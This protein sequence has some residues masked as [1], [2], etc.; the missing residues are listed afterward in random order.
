MSTFN[1]QKAFTL[2]EL[3]VVIG[4]AGIFVTVSA[5]VYTTLRQR[6]NLEVVAREVQ[7]VFNLARDRALASDGEQNFGVYVNIAT[8]E[9][10]L[11]PGASYDAGNPNNE[12]FVIPANIIVF[13]PQFEGGGNEAVFNRLTGTTSQF[14]QLTLQ[15]MAD[16]SKTS[17]ICIF[18]TGTVETRKTTQCGQAPLGHANGTIDADLANFPGHWGD[19]AQSFTTGTSALYAREAQLYLRRTTL[20]PSDIYVE[21]RSGNTSGP[22]LGRSWMVLGSSLPASLAWVTFTFPAPVFLLANTQ[23][24]LRLRSFYDSTVYDPLNPSFSATGTI[25]WGYSHSAFVPPAYSGGDAWRYVEYI[26]Y[27]GAGAI[28]QQL[29]PLDQYDFNF[30]LIYGI[31]PP[32]G[33]DSRHLEFELD[34]PSN[35]NHDGWS[36]RGHTTL[37]LTFQD[38]PNPDV[39]RS[40]AMA[41]YFSNAQSEFD[42]QES[43]NVNG[44]TEILRIHSLYIDKYDTVLSIHRD[45]GIN[46]K[47]VIIAID[48]R[49]I[50]SYDASGAPTV[51][52]YGGEAIYR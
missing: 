14:G 43:V 25:H 13:M 46:N 24:F 39:V 21:V 15:D 5:G 6:S 33:A 17:T 34:D 41:G 2:I 12:K 16:I 37:T 3:L 47:G 22:V 11:F 36:I 1:C 45:R 8:H 44:D 28:G 31:D 38:P 51:G 10:F 26:A 7:S 23:Y 9:Y 32:A 49:N 18:S 50:V 40:I 52:S 20:A 48:G 30:R 29:G 35:S 42:W 27:G 19:P 4:I